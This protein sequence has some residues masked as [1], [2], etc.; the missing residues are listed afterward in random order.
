MFTYIHIHEIKST[1]DISQSKPQ[2]E[3]MK[4]QVGNK[5]MYN[6]TLHYPW[7]IVYL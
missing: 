2:E 7:Q 6:Y 5:D 4:G 1:E 3:L